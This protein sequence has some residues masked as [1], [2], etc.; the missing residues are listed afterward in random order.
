MALAPTV[1]GIEARL[2]DEMG[3]CLVEGD[4]GPAGDEDVGQPRPSS[5]G[6]AGEIGMKL[7]WARGE[8]SNSGSA[9]PS[10]IGLASEIRL[11][12]LTSCLSVEF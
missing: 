8:M 9:W 12:L 5:I 3:P 11:V 7:Q 4:V 2:A 1:K 10:S 6:L